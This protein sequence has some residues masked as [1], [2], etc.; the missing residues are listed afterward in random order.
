MISV[1][2]MMDRA[3]GEQTARR[4]GGDGAPPILISGT[5]RSGTTLLVQYFTALGFETGFTLEEA[6]SRVDGISRGGLE[7]PLDSTPFPYVAKSPFYTGSLARK[8][9]Q[10]EFPVQCC[11]IPVRDLFAAAESRRQVSARA[12]AVSRDARH[13]GGL[14]FGAQGNPARQEARLAQQFYKLVQTLVAHHIPIHFLSFPAF[15]RDP[16][17]LFA[18]LEPLLVRHGVT[19]QESAA[20]LA[21]VVV[22]EAIHDFQEPAAE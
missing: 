5:G 15:A 7:T 16:E 3:A 21:S 11:I 1:A 4:R 19:A 2:L 10:E 9:D 14:A 22:P 8:L 12:E 20:A 6:R 18:G 17:E 13:P